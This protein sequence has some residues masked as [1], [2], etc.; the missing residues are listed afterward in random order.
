LDQKDSGANL[1]QFVVISTYSYIRNSPGNEMLNYD[2]YANTISHFV[3]GT[4][5]NKLK[6][7][8]LAKGA[9]YKSNK[10][11]KNGKIVHIEK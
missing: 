6:R 10:Q 1:I 9:I 7:T 8:Q 3:Y 5:S 4:Q 11:L 2:K